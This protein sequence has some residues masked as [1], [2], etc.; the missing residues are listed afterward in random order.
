MCFFPN[1]ATECSVF[2]LYQLGIYKN[3]FD[4]HC[5]GTLKLHRNVIKAVKKFYG[6]FAKVQLKCMPLQ[7]TIRNNKRL[8]N[9]S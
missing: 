5:I 3:I 7:R 2:Q 4:A 1:Y 8:H 9:S 6:D